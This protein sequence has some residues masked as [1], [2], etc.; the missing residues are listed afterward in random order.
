MRLL[1][2]QKTVHGLVTLADNKL[3]KMLHVLT[4]DLV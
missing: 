2:S 3:L 4:F 1:F